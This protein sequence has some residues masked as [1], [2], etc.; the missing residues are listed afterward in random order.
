MADPAKDHLRIA[1]IGGDRRELEI[2]RLAVVEGFD[3][4]TFG[5]PVSPR[6]ELQEPFVRS[7]SLRSALKNAQIAIFS[8]AATVNGRVFAPSV[9]GG[10]PLG[11]EQLG[12]LAPKAVLLMGEVDEELKRSIAS[13]EL[14]LARY[15]EFETIRAARGPIVAEAALSLIV[16]NTDVSLPELKVAIVGY[17]SI[18]ASLAKL[19]RTVGVQVKVFVRRKESLEAAVGQFFE[20][21]MIE[22][23]PAE[24]QNFNVLISA[25]SGLVMG[26]RKIAML[27]ESLL[28][29]DLTSPPGSL[30]LEEA[31]RRGMTTL[32]P[33]GLG[34]TA[35]R[36][37]AYAQWA[38][39]KSI[40][41][42]AT[43]PS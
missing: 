19:L 18:G 26:P 40:I 4:R 36:T 39:I 22:A 8:V 27:S 17:G 35:P 43:A 32:R 23:L 10:I 38:V 33:R 37:L 24:S 11:R 20:A 14:S 9:P 25:A 29:M 34:G 42:K 1:I 6:N 5:V 12:D 2:A 41:D 31:Q 16:Q 3:V 7:P 15:D 30:D 21:G 13:L 28:L